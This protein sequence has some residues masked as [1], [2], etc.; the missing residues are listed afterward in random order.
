MFLRADLND[1]GGTESGVDFPKYS[2]VHI[3]AEGALTRRRG[4]YGWIKSE[5]WKELGYSMREESKKIV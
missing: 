3:T 2:M 1:A 5:D 4:I